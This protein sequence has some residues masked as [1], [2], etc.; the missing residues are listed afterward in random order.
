MNHVI[1]ESPEQLQMLL[2][3]LKRLDIRTLRVSL[4]DGGAKFKINNG[5]WSPPLGKVES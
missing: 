2:S 5:I 1:I 3:E 4:N